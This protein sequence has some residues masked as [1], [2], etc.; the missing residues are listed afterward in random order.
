[1]IELSEIYFDG[2]SL[3]GLPQCLPPVSKEGVVHPEHA[4]GYHSVIAAIQGTLVCLC[5]ETS[6]VGVVNF[7][8]N[9]APT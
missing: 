6:L 9:D 5:I 1:M 7:Y 2:E 3:E 4:R 8:C